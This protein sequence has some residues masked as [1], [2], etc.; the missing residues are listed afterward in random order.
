MS[1]YSDSH[2]DES[3]RNTSWYKVFHL[4]PEGAKVL[5]VGCSSG[6][7]G[8]E[9]INRKHCKVDGIELDKRD[10]ELARKTLH[11]VYQKNVET[12][13][14]DEIDNDYDIIYFGDVIEHLLNPIDSLK[15]I[16]RH[17]NP[18]GKIVF[19][20]PN[21]GHVSIRLF[22]LGGQFEYAETGLLDKT[23]LHFYTLGE[24]RRVFGE[25]QLRITHLDFVEKDF[26]QAL[27]R[28]ELAKHGLKAD[29][30][31]FDRMAHVEASAFQF[32]GSAEASA[33]PI[34]TQKLKA[35]SPVDMFDTYHKNIVNDYETRINSLQTGK[36]ANGGHRLKNAVREPHKVLWR[37]LKQAAKH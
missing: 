9:L 23:H 17:L 15:K 2:F 30:A 29:K 35:F 25:A 32:V 11:K 8:K 36:S 13:N 37:R 16:K 21:M 3:N 22:L 31:F 24:V 33:K 20:I 28:K 4:I 27:I 19:S 34:K 6:N 14:L 5:D 7:F 18:K 10:Y 12:D 26:P 1:N